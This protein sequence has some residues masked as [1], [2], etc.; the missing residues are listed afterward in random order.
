MRKYKKEGIYIKNIK[1]D[2][3]NMK[4]SNAANPSLTFKPIDFTPP[5][6]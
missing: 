1:K 5:L 6:T 4:H 2:D 3:I